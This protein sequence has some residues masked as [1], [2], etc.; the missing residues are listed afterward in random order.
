M[1]CNTGDAIQNSA[2]MHSAAV[3]SAAMHSARLLAYKLLVP[4]LC[5]SEGLLPKPGRKDLQCDDVN[6]A[7]LA[8]R[9]EL[10]FTSAANTK[11]QKEKK[12]SRKGASM[13][14]QH[15]A[16]SYHTALRS[17]NDKV[18]SASTLYYKLLI[19]TP[20]RYILLLALSL[21]D[22]HFI[23]IFLEMLTINFQFTGCHTRLMTGRSLP[24]GFDVDWHQLRNLSGCQIAVIHFTR[25]Y[26][27]HCAT[28]F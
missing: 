9:M 1:I 8:R 2:A 12:L 16:D 14:G 18:C 23:A 3:H 24:A 21:N 28:V 10:D 19:N 13:A 25:L 17:L 20:G 4:F 6:A 27:C 22:P 7:D 5:S 11:V 26:Y 15:A